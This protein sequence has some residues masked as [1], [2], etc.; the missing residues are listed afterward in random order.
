MC[1][2]WMCSHCKY[3]VIT[4]KCKSPL[5]QFIP[6][7][8]GYIVYIFVNMRNFPKLSQILLL[9]IWK[10]MKTS[11]NSF[12]QLLFFSLNGQIPYYKTGKFIATIICL[13][14]FSC[15]KSIDHYI[16]ISRINYLEQENIFRN[17]KHRSPRRLI[18]PRRYRK[19]T[20][21]IWYMIQTIKSFVGL[22]CCVKYSTWKIISVRSNISAKYRTRFSEKH[23]NW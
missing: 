22:G 21:S 5:F 15:F 9:T 19:N 7:F 8:P 11:F 10:Y 18:H 3:L 16:R 6:Q 17:Q 2:Y 13:V 1:K 14:K 12:I 20:K 4:N 23:T